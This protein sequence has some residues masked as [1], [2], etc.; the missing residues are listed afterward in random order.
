MLDGVRA[1][2]NTNAMSRGKP[3]INFRTTPDTRQKLW[4]MASVYGSQTTSEFMR[5]MVEA[6]CSDDAEKVQT[7]MVRLF[8]RLGERK[9][10]KLTLGPKVNPPNKRRNHARR[11]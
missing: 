3:T 9:Q 6:M 7:F 4:E 10:L 1:R 11:E 5:E 2:C 8:T